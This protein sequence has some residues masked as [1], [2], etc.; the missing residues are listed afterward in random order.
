MAGPGVTVN[1]TRYDEF[2]FTSPVQVVATTEVTASSDAI[3]ITT[4]TIDIDDNV[5]DRLAPTG[6]WLRVLDGG[7][8]VCA[9]DGMNYPQKDMRKRWDGVWVHKKNWEQR[10]PQDLIKSVKEKDRRPDSIV[11]QG[12]G[13]DQGEEYLFVEGAS[14]PP[15]S[16]AASSGDIIVT[17]EGVILTTPPTAMSLT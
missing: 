5:I 14:T 17:G 6:D 1:V 16:L 4:A 13:S 8:F 9:I 7:A 15:F 2:F 3:T 11:E 10:H 12:Y